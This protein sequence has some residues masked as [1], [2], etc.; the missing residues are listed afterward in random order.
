MDRGLE[1]YNLALKYNKGDGVEENQSQ[2]IYYLKEA[3]DF[4]YYRAY[5][6]L[7]SIYYDEQMFDEAIDAFI[8]AIKHG[9]D[10][11]RDE[12]IASLYNTN[13]FEKCL[14]YIF[15][16]KTINQ[17]TEKIAICSID[18]YS[19]QLI[20]DKDFPYADI[21][22]VMKRFS[23][24]KNS[25]LVTDAIRRKLLEKRTLIFN[26]FLAKNINTLYTKKDY[27][28]FESLVEDTRYSKFLDAEIA[29]DFYQKCAVFELNETGKNNYEDILKKYK[30]SPYYS[31][32]AKNV[33][34]RIAES[35]LEK[36]NIT[37][38]DVDLFKKA[39][40]NLSIYQTN[41]YMNRIDKK[42]D[43]CINNSE[44]DKAL[45]LSQTFP[46]S[47]KLCDV[48]DKITERSEDNEIQ[49]MK[50]ALKKNSNDYPLMYKLAFSLMHPRNA[51]NK[52]IPLAIKLF[53]L[54]FEN[55]NNA[56]SLEELLHFY[57]ISGYADLLCEYVEKGIKAKLPISDTYLNI[58]SE[59]IEQNE[60]ALLEKAKFKKEL[61]K[62][63][64]EYLVHITKLCNLEGIRK[65]GILSRIQ[66]EYKND[67]YYE[68]LDK[69]KYDDEYNR[70]STSVTCMNKYYFKS[71]KEEGILTD[72]VI[73][74]I[75]ANILCDPGVKATFYVT[76]AA[77]RIMR[78]MSGQSF[79]AFLKMFRS[80]LTVETSDGFLREYDRSNRAENQTTDIQAE[81][82]I[83]RIIPKKYI[84]KVWYFN[85]GE[86]EE[87]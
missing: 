44:Y 17:E 40:S 6:Y 8:K 33:Y 45:L 87:F 68:V 85:T 69:D 38:Y 18:N 74:F 21:D 36:E 56:A 52:D 61:Q 67:I 20:S 76:N 82:M 71:K 1:Y 80:N 84:K 60:I 39:C 79:K 75:D 46:S 32:I 47:Q 10:E 50:N 62:R 64:I 78:N 4:G 41:E 53:T 31:I 59:R 7:G 2:A 11:D 16:S 35:F 22:D 37:N 77:N 34:I 58:Y 23:N 51:K 70:I 83:D 81:V 54:C 86:I 72:P 15:S 55:T 5:S 73:L 49:E 30:N 65:Y 26:T 25:A 13:Q 19:K 24:W 29:K 48:K 14:A 63:G 3:I 27:D 12:L 9:F 43:Y 28:W 66:L 42:I 57:K